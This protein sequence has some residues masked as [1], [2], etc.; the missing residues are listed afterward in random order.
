MDN[1][2]VAVQNNFPTLVGEI[3]EDTATLIN[4]LQVG[5]VV[6][7][8]GWARLFLIWKDNLFLNATYVMNICNA[9]N[10]EV[11]DGHSACARCESSDIVKDVRYRFPT[12]ESYVEFVSRS[13]GK[14][15]QTIFNRL[16]TY[17][18][19]SEERSV[20]PSYVFEMN[21]ISS[22]AAQ[23]LAS[24]EELESINLINDSWEDTVVA[25]L[26]HDSKTEMLRFIKHDILNEPSYYSELSIDEMSISV[27]RETYPEDGEAILEGYELALLGTW[28][29][30]MLDWLKRRLS[31]RKL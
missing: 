5:N 9:C 29:E 27:F 26:S 17:R 20:A 13:T 1:E 15:R 30:H 10:T 14:S 21:L 31:V 16:R 12:L 4:E 3:E 25:A 19:L 23:K 7:E 18:V 8:R 24:A 28:P 2:L 6:I 22:G 11:P